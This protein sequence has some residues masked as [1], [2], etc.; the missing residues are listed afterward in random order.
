M[1][2]KNFK[3]GID[4]ILG[5]QEQHK[6]KNTMKNEDKTETRTTIVI[7]SYQI[8]KLKAIAFWD[9]KSLKVVIEDAMDMYLVNYEKQNG[10]V[11]NIKQ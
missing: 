4:E 1:A 2:K 6:T 5:V 11:K 7:K 10:E 3:N 8:N 9:R